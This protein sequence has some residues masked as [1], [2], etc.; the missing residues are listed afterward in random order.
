V[1]RRKS[2]LGSKAMSRVSRSNM[3][4]SAKSRKTDIIKA[5]LIDAI[6]KMDDNE[7]E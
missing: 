7:V 4:F 3:S 2:Q 6:S 5:K 1:S